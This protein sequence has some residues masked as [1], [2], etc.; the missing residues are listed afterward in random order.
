MSG[1]QRDRRSSP[2]GYR[3]WCRFVRTQLRDKKLSSA[4]QGEGSDEAW[5]WFK[6]AGHGPA[7]QEGGGGQT[8]G[9]LFPLRRTLGPRPLLSHFM[10]SLGRVPAKEW[11]GSWPPFLVSKH[12]ALNGTAGPAAAR[13]AGQVM[14]PHLKLRGQACRPPFQKEPLEPAAHL[15]RRVPGDEQH[16]LSFPKGR[17]KRRVYSY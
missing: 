12:N 15:V 11:H 7:A 3:G 1:G 14:G 17:K 5:T 2:C 4:P 16:Y 13:P 9:P 8:E 10:G 6:R